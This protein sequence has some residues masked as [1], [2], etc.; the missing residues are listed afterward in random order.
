ME[1]PPSNA[2][3]APPRTMAQLIGLSTMESHKAC[4]FLGFDLGRVALNSNEINKTSWITGC[5]DIDTGL[6]MIVGR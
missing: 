5:I 2:H 6:P 1:R 4:Y 3:H